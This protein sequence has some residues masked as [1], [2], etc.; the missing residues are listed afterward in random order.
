MARGSQRER[1]LRALTDPEPAPTSPAFATA[2]RAAVALILLESD[3][4]LELLLIE[5]A[6]RS[7]DPWSGHMALPGGH[8]ALEDVDM[9]ATAERETLEEV[10]L[11]L[12]HAAERVGRLSVRS[13]AQGVEIAVQPFVYLLQTRPALTLSEEVRQAMWVPVGPLARGERRTVFTL[14]RAGQHLRFPAWDIGGHTVWGL[15]YRVLDEF[16]RRFNAVS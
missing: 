15:T 14:A 5:R 7:G 2:R 12:R 6:T 8:E 1:L 3:A 4:A 9:S 10:G 16:F 11:D 13:P